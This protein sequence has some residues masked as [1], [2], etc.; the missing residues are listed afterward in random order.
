M[1]GWSPLSEEGYDLT[2][3]LLWDLIHIRYDWALT[4]LPSNCEYSNKFDIQH[5]LCWKKRGFV[6]LRHNY[7]NIRNITLILLK[8][9]C[10]GVHVDEVRLDISVYGFWQAGMVF[11]DV[12]VFKPITKRYADIELSKVY[13]INKK[14]KKK[15]TYNERI[16]QAVNARNI[17]HA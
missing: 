9:V 6:S 5:T 2:K 14:E 10:K 4:R 15:K 16:L 8:E 13:E 1:V 17:I 12:R 7:I 3:Q 11:L